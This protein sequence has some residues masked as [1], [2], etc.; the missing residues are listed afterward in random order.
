MKDL[1]AKIRSLKGGVWLPL[2]LLIALM[3]LLSSFA[4]QDG[5]QDMTAQ[6]MRISRTLSLI[7]GAGECRITLYCQEKESAFSP[8][9][10]PSGAV[11][12]AQ[13]ARNIEVRMHLMQAAEA[14]LG[15]PPDRIEIF[16][17]E[18]LP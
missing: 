9:S 3:L 11:I 4:A 1:F 7:Q 13:G 5:S 12:L 10:A 6:E 2:L 15:L 18:E 8:G 16:P 14:L 17:M